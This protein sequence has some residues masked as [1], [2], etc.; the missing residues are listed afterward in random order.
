MDLHYEYGSNKYFR[1]NLSEKEKQDIHGLLVD[2]HIV[3]DEEFPWMTIY[4]YNDSEYV[5]CLN[6]LGEC[7]YEGSE[8]NERF[9]VNMRLEDSKHVISFIENFINKDVY[10]IK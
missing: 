3:I 1:R 5:V 7:Y 10:F 9:G 2:D 4:L 8:H 6:F